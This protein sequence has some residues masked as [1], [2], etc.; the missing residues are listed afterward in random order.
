MKVTILVST[1]NWPAALELSLRSMFSQTVL[2]DEI[3]IADDGSTAETAELINQLKRETN[4]PIKHI[5]HED[6][7][8]RKTIVLNQAIAQAIGNYILQV[9]GDV[10]L[11]PYFVQDHL[12]LAQANA[13][14]C[15]S[16]VKLTPELTERMLHSPS[17]ASLN[18]RELPLASY[19]IASGPSYYVNS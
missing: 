8:F 10:I 1:Y 6:K 17:T 9:D 2:P 5:W 15:G 18:W 4:I 13:F 14:V 11:S 16:R 12:E 7:G 19:S 3:V